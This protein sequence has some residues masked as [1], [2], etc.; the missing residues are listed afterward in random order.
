MTASHTPG[1]WKFKLSR[2]EQ[3]AHISG[4]GWEKF[5][6]VFV[7]CDG[8]PNREGEAN[9]LIA[10]APD[11]LELL[12]GIDAELLPSHFTPRIHAVI[13]KIEGK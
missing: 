3:K 9:R 12:R 5:A 6:R 1:P 11:M 13:A 7:V 10:A 4:A 2:D 8:E